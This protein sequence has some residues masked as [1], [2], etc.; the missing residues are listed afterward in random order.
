[1]AQAPS[2][3]SKCVLAVYLSKA[4]TDLKLD[5][6]AQ[7][8]LTYAAGSGSEECVDLL[9]SYGVPRS[10][11]AIEYAITEQYTSKSTKIIEKLLDAGF[12]EFKLGWFFQNPYYGPDHFSEELCLFML[13]RVGLT[14]D[15]S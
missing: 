10:E 11:D 3:K 4:K 13:K 5:P 9:L 12:K 14:F 8:A 1:M 15:Q 6:D 2:H 7:R